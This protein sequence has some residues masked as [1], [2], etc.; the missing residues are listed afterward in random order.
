MKVGLA[1]VDE[2]KLQTTVACLKASGADILGVTTDV[3]KFQGM[4]QQ[5]QFSEIFAFPL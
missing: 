1:D 3:S 5:T 2:E 4:A